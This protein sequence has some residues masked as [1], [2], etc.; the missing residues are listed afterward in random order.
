M[1][2]Y[3]KTGNSCRSIGSHDDLCATSWV[4]HSS[5]HHYSSRPWRPGA[6]DSSSSLVSQVG[7]TL[8]FCEL[9]RLTTACKKL[10]CAS[11]LVSFSR[12]KFASSNSYAWKNNLS[13]DVTANDLEIIL[14]MCDHFSTADAVDHTHTCS[15]LRWKKLLFSSCH[16]VYNVKRQSNCSPSFFSPEANAS[17][18]RRSFVR[19]EKVI[20]SD[21][22]KRKGWNVLQVTLPFASWPLPCHLILAEILVPSACT[23][24]RDAL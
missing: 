16:H 13:H 24:R 2:F 7:K 10:T 9:A 6:R 20:A 18:A 15:L 11:P 21:K 4:A 5:E 22:W 1:N 23:K 12:A 17:I 8:L 3:G 19:A 14:C